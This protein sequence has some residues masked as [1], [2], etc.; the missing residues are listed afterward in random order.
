V[1]GFIERLTA[2]LKALDQEHDHEH[3]QEAAKRA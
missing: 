3:E 1:S 2:D